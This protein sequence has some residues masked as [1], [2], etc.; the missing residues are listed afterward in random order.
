MG[1]WKESNEEK[2]AKI[3]KDV[4][5][6]VENDSDFS[7]LMIASGKNEG[8]SLVHGNAAELLRG[9]FRTDRTCKATIDAAASSSFSAK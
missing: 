9:L 2:L 1:F 4:Q 7:V 3:T 6:L 8:Q 5:W